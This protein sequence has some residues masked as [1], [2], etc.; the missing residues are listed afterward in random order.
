MIRIHLWEGKTLPINLAKVPT[1]HRIAVG[2][3]LE[4]WWRY[5]GRYCDRGNF[6]RTLLSGSRLSWP[7]LAKARSGLVPTF[8]R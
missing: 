7:R 1:L 6:P 5:K 8:H 2:R 4:S 3:N